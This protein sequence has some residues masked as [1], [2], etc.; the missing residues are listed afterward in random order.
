M[1]R[2]EDCTRSAIASAMHF[3]TDEFLVDVATD[4]VGKCV[5]IGL[6]LTIL[7]RD[8]P[9]TSCVLRQRGTAQQR[10]DHRDQHD[11]NGR[12]RPPRRRIRLVT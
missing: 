6:A 5:L 10:Q 8:P 9:R 1:P 4:Y 2:Q 7:E 11:L 12:L 3:L